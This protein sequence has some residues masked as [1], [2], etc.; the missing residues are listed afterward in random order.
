MEALMKR[1]VTEDGGHGRSGG[2]RAFPRPKKC[3]EVVRV[4]VD[5]ALA[6]VKGMRTHIKVPEVAQQLQFRVVE[7][8]MWLGKGADVG[9]DIEGER[10]APNDGV[11]WGRVVPRAVDRAIGFSRK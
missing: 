1:E 3:G 7:A 9:A 11:R 5:G 6:K 2:G 10:D 8:T 4:G